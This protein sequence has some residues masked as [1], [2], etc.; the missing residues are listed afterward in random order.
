VLGFCL[1]KSNF[2]ATLT[3]QVLSLKGE[4]RGKQDPERVDSL[5]AL[6]NSALWVISLLVCCRMKEFL[7][8]TYSCLLMLLNLVNQFLS[9]R[10]TYFRQFKPWDGLNME[11]DTLKERIARFMLQRQVLRPYVNEKPENC[12]PAMP[13]GLAGES[14]AASLILR[15]PVATTPR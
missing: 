10:L 15:S 13:S 14:R 3:H 9:L 1:S 4:R 8:E 11:R 12:N 7:Q 2:V 6:V 5:H